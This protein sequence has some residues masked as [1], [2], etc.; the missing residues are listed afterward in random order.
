[1]QKRIKLLFL[2][3][4]LN[5]VFLNKSQGQEAKSKFFFG[6]VTINTG[7]I[8]PHSNRVKH[9]TGDVFAAQIKLYQN[10]FS[11]H[12]WENPFKATK[13]GYSASYIH[14]NNPIIGDLWGANLFM[15]P[16]IFK[17]HNLHFYTHLGMGLAYATNKYNSETNP[18]NFMISTDIS[19]FFNL[20]FNLDLRLSKEFSLGL[21]AGFAHCSNG[22]VLLPNL[23]INILNY[24]VNIGYRIFDDNIPLSN[25]NNI[26]TE[27]K[28]AHDFTLGIA[29]R[30][31]NEELNKYYLILAGDYA[32]NLF[33]NRKNILSLNLHYV[34]RQGEVNDKYFTSNYNSYYG[35]ALGHELQ[36][37]KLSVITQLGKYIY[38]TRLN[39]HFLYARLGLRYYVT[40]S[41]YG[42]ITLTNRNASADYVQ[43]AIGYRLR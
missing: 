21:N 40:K 4:L 11:T 33:L 30:N 39:Q 37:R 27:K 29:T 28:W 41:I 18:T 22:A 38:D 23:G 19:F 8:V 34:L 10:L 13:F 24:G 20:K 15:E 6:G 32:L 43:Y 31:V 12:E 35:L 16:S 1:M 14:T 9:L 17:Y 25:K 5:V 26:D 42:M 3:L 2:F 36:L 7:K